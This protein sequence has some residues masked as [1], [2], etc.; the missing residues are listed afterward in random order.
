MFMKKL[1]LTL[2]I[3]GTT[4]G[5]QAQ[6]APDPCCTGPEAYVTPYMCARV[7][8]VILYSGFG[9]INIADERARCISMGGSELFYGPPP[10][11]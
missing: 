2:L 11:G 6:I 1:L 5:T 8:P 9:Y 4:F 7:G 3:A 10:G